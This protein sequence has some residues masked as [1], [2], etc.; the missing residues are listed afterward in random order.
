MNFI[1][2]IK[3]ILL[4]LKF[5]LTNENQVKKSILKIDKKKLKINVLINNAGVASGSIFEMTS[6]NIMKKVFEVN[7]FSQ[8]KFIQ[9][10]LKNLKKSQSSSIINIGSLSGIVAERGFISYGSSKAALM[11]ATKILSNEL[12]N[13]GIRVNAIAPN[14]TKSKM[15]NLMSKK[16]IESFKEQSFLKKECTVNDIANLISFLASDD[17]KYLNGQV[18]RLDGGMKL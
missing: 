16:S 13:Y 18:I 14:I 9:L 11:Y 10:M 15:L 7:F 4:V 5:D 12:S 1:E 17:A 8:L 3:N 2:R 6:I